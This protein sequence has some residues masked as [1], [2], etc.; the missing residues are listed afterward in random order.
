MF[1]RVHQRI[2]FLV[3]LL[4]GLTIFLS[5]YFSFGIQEITLTARDIKQKMISNMIVTIAII[6]LNYYYTKIPNKLFEDI[7]E[8]S[9]A[10]DFHCQEKE[11]FFNSVSKEIRNPI[12]SLLGGLELLSHTFHGD[13]IEK[14][15]LEVCSSCGG[16]VLNLVSNLLDLPKINSGELK[17]TVL[18]GDPKEAVMR[19]I[20]ITKNLAERKGLYLNF[21]DYPAIP[22]MLLLDSIKLSQVVLNIVMNAIKFTKI[23]GITVK[24]HWIL[25]HKIEEIKEENN[26]DDKGEL[27]ISLPIEDHEHNIIS[28][29]YNSEYYG[30][31]KSNININNVKGKLN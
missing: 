9:D 16:F 13:E 7:K 17:I 11:N 1:E 27:Y 10:V 14:G 12:Q 29:P 28:F 15:L 31:K 5:F 6:S 25:E 22:S 21:V 26:A 3:M 18:P 23:G 20:R 30:S 8:Y 4:Y 19:V 24:L 2:C